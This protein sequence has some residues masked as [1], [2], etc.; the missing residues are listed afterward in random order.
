M[1]ILS[2]V[3]DLVVAG[4]L[5]VTI[6]YAVLLSRRLGALRN[7]KQQLE[8]LV[9]SLDASSTRA[10]AGIAALKEAAEEIGRTLQQKID[11]GQGLRNDL[12]YI[13][14]V[15]GGVAD[16]LETAIRSTRDET[17]KPAQSSD[18]APRPMRRAI[19]ENIAPSSA[20]GNHDEAAGPSESAEIA[21]F[22]SRAERL[23]RRALEARR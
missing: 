11:Q 2:I 6:T 9:Q 17:K 19:G 8:A 10:N 22:P 21:G 14:D 3:L 23:L 20:A 13:L 12:N 16:R 4:L 15:G 1:T 5:A 7:D 18:P